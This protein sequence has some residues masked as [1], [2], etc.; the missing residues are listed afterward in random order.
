MPLA[1]ARGHDLFL[2][3]VGKA[4]NVP[5]A[6]PDLSVSFEEETVYAHKFLLAVRAPAIGEACRS[7]MLIQHLQMAGRHTDRGLGLQAACLGMAGSNSIHTIQWQA[8]ATPWLCRPCCAGS[9]PAVWTS[10]L[11]QCQRAWSC[12]SRSSLQS[13]LKKQ[14]W[15]GIAKV[16]DSSHHHNC[17]CSAD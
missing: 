12:V 8:V 11:M 13:W 6:Y 16:T 7:H 17:Q 14:T 4:F 15:L 1:G 10:P 2:D 5:E 3:F 9:I